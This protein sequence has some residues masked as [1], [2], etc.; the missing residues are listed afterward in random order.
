MRR[1]DIPAAPPVAGERGDLLRL[2]D[3]R[4]LAVA[5]LDPGAGRCVG[6]AVRPV[7]VTVGGWRE[8]LDGADRDAAGAPAVPA[9][10]ALAIGWPWSGEA[11]PESPVRWQLIERDPTAAICA[12]RCV[13]RLDRERVVDLTLSAWLDEGLLRLR[14]VA[15][16]AGDTTLLRPHFRVTL[17]GAGT[18]TGRSAAAGVLVLRRAGASLR[19]TVPREPQDRVVWSITS[20]DAATISTASAGPRR[21]LADA[22]SA[23][24]LTMAVGPLD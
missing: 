21:A 19:L 16:A 24:T 13:S 20:D 23:C 12:C 3:P 15:R 10:G 6:Y 5:W 9:G 18:T 2:V 17:P 7:G 14:L 11:A 4:G 1:F 22:D 8:L